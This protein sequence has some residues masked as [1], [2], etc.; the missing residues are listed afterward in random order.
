M[1]AEIEWIDINSSKPKTEDQWDSI[2][3]LI[4][5]KTEHEWESDVIGCFYSKRGGFH[6]DEGLEYRNI[7]HFAY[8]PKHPSDK[9]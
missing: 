2:P 8:M 1:K 6:T 9:K 7:T 4:A 5:I 3:I